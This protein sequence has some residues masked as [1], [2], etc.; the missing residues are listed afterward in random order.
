VIA[1]TNRDL[2]EEVHRGSF[3]RDLYYRLNVFPITMPALRERRED[4]PALVH[5]LVDRLSRQIGK[6]V[7]S[8]RPE[9]LH[10]LEQHD[11]PGNIRELENVLQ[12]A[13]ILSRDGT[14]ELPGIAQPTR[15]MSEALP[16]RE[17]SRALVDIER[18]HIRRVLTSTGGR[19]EGAS[20]A[21]TVLGLRPSTLRSL[22]RRLGIERAKRPVLGHTD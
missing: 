4:L 2:A 16:L 18:D 22:M 6:P 7:N 20:G 5:H 21:A 19:I 8:I 1:A 17:E 13:I 9:T 10:A 14:L 11:W 15:E 12:Q 3:R